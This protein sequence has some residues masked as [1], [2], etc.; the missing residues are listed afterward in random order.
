MCAIWLCLFGCIAHAQIR[1]QDIPLTVGL[2][3]E[4]KLQPFGSYE[5][6][7]TAASFAIRN[8]QTSIDGV[9]PGLNSSLKCSAKNST[10]VTLRSLSLQH[11]PL[12]ISADAHIR[13]C[14]QVPF[15]EGDIAVLIPIGISH[16]SQTI[17]LQADSPVVTGSGLTLV[18][19]VPA[20]NSLLVTNARKVIAPKLSKIVI[21]INTQIQ[22]GF[23]SVRRWMTAYSVAVQTVQINYQG[24]DLVV[25]VQLSGQ[26][27]LATANKRLVDF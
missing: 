5:V 25:G 26:I 6:A 16:T 20:P 19:F 10:E 4:S 24:G 23:F 8:V 1:I 17:A 3:A 12:A 2:S 22:R 18:G 21:A 14:H 13:D 15:Y 11:S 7:S 9:L 27:P